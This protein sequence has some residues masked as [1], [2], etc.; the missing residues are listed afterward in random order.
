MPA[1]SKEFVDIQ[2]TVEY[3]FTLKG[4]SDMIRAYYSFHIFK[5]IHFQY[6]LV[7][8]GTEVVYNV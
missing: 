7:K 8:K 1:L 3:G 6:L 5:V 2:A 4:V